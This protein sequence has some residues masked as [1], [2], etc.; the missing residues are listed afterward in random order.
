M[1]S[2]ARRL[3]LLLGEKH[4]VDV[5]QHTTSSDGH[6][7]EQFVEL[8]VVADGKLQVPGDDPFALVVAGCVSSKLK[9]FGAQ[10]LKHGGHVHGGTTAE[11][12]GKALS[13]HVAT[14][15][16][17]RE[18]QTGTGRAGGGFRSLGAARRS[19]SSF[20]TFSWHVDVRSA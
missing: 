12:R 17:D 6:T 18:L 3:L 20:S 2:V 7:T 19:L 8:L 11:T 9:N 14:D 4:L 13:A 10:V 15:T 16:A 1:K 5:W